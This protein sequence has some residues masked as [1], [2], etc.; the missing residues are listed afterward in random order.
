M[1][2]SAYD[3]VKEVNNSYILPEYY[4][5]YSKQ[6]KYRNYYTFLKRYNN[7]D[8]EYE[9]FL[10]M[11]DVPYDNI[12]WYSSNMDTKGVVKINLKPIWLLSKFRELTAKTN[13][14]LCLESKDE[15]G[16]V[17]KIEY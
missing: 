14:K 5:L 8:K 2:F 1:N 13:V 7:E 10:C 4:R 16:E 17:Y 11:C 9:Y 6:I 3:L 12:E 15:D